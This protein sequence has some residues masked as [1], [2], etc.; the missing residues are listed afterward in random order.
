[1]SSVRRQKRTA[2]Q[3]R[4]RVR[5]GASD[6]SLTGLAGLVAVEELTERLALVAE[7]DAGIGPIKQR[8]RGL[9]SN[10]QNLWMALGEVTRR[11]APSRG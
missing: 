7:L 11:G 3:T 5:I 9:T 6:A 2:K 10:D 8:A 4:R 1:V